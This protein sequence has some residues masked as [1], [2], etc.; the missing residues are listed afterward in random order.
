M[1][2]SAKAVLMCAML[3]LALNGCAGDQAAE[4]DR[5]IEYVRNSEFR[6]PYLRVFLTLRDG[7]DVSVNTADDAVSSR[8]A[9]TPIPGHRARDWTFVKDIEDGTSVV[10]ALASW[11]DDNPSDY[12][13]AGWWAEFRASICRTFHSKAR[14]GTPSSTARRPTS[15]IPSSSRLEGQATYLGPAGGLYEYVPGA[16]WEKPKGFPCWTSMKARSRLRRTLR[17]VP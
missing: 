1:S 5:G 14:T 13:M 7:R 15:P 4:G 8:P 10:Y 6:G 17:T 2:A 11:D 3:A 9:E 12:L 16:D